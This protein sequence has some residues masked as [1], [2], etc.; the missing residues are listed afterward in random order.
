MRHLYLI[1]AFSAL[2]C[3]T[4]C[5]VQSKKITTPTP[6]GTTTSTTSATP[7]K[8]AP[9]VEPS[10]DEAKQLVELVSKLVGSVEN[11]FAKKNIELTP[12]G[13]IKSI[14]LD[15]SDLDAA[16]F[17]LFAKQPDL[18]KLHISNYRELDDSMIEL[19][20]PLKNLKSFGAVN[21]NI[22]NGGV[23]AIVTQFPNLRELDISSNTLLSGE[24]MAEVA[25]LTELETLKA[26]QCRFDDFS[27]LEISQMPKLKSIDI[28]TC[29][30]IGNTGLE[31]LAELPM[32]T[33]VMHRTPA[34][35]DSGIAA[36]GAAK[37]L[38]SLHMEDFA[39][40]DQA[41]KTLKQFEKLNSL[42]VFRCS[43]FG[44]E[45]VLALKGLPLNRLTLRGLPSLDD[46]GMA[47]FRELP[48]LKRLYLQELPV[49]DAGIMNLVGL[50][51]LEVLDIW[52]IPLMT[53]KS[54]ETISKLTNLRE[55]SIRDTELTDAAIDPILS[56]PKLQ[57]LVIKGNAKITESGKQKLRD[58][59]SKFRT[60]D[61]GE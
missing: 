23:V 48:Q 15:T 29:M 8:A 27:M 46:T 18:E 5:P 34:V 59:K 17:E 30:E 16:S 35:N 24:V 4:G 41:G 60:L 11:A 12:A 47:V 37:N 13:T 25:K 53:D 54:M 2:I 32:L 49:S 58:A 31:Y 19:L 40:S 1:L 10:T 20:A 42:I 56:L 55:L 39:L 28:R 33:S 57:R 26:I 21:S 22:T 3:C 7:P 52:M 36:L 50:K 51:D 44:S 38:E 9:K 61:I 45:G 14:T 43:G 6:T